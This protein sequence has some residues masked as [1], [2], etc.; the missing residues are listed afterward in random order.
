[1]IFLKTKEQIDFIDQANRFVQDCLDLAQEIVAPGVA[2]LEIDLAIEEY[3]K[4]NKVKASFKGYK[5]FP[6]H[7]CVSINE[8]I[9][10]GIPSEQRIIQDGD[11]VSVDMGVIYKGFVGDAAR[12]FLVG[13]V[14]EE[15]RQLSDLTKKA[16]YAGIEQMVV[17]NRLH[18]IGKAV[19]KIARANKYGNLKHFCGHGVGFD[20][21]ECPAVYSY[22]EPREPNIHLRN[23]LVLALEPMFTLG[24]DVGVLGKDNWV[25]TTKDKSLSSHW[26]LSIAIL[27]GQPKILGINE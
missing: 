12:T 8:E 23:G 20:L 21:H 27:D 19:S 11:L 5:G 1:M 3:L 17:G 2:T 18:D 25:V 4:E 22:I 6:A 16:L 13:D 9:V 26:E 15:A 24:S 7:C 10:H 14:S